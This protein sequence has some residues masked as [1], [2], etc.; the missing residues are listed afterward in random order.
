MRTGEASRGSALIEMAIVLPVFGLLLMGAV[1]LSR[2][3]YLNEIAVS[4]ARAGAQGALAGDAQN[5]DLKAIEAIAVADGAVA[6]LTAKATVV[7]ACGVEA[8]QPCEAVK[9]AANRASY[10]RVETEAPERPLLRY[11]G[12]GPELTV[13]GSATVRLQ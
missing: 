11:P 8:A 13:R 2:T 12:V 5:P 10:L 4:A 6:G 1:D 7:C 9:C 3:L